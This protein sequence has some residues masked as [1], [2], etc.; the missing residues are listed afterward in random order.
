MHP[1]N[2]PIELA[3]GILTAA[4]HTTAAAAHADI[5]QYQSNIVAVVNVLARNLIRQTNDVALAK[6]PWIMDLD[7]LVKR[8]YPLSMLEWV[9][10]V[11]TK[12]DPPLH[13]HW[14]N[15]CVES[16][17][18]HGNVQAL[19]WFCGK[20]GKETVKWF[21]KNALV[22]A[23]ANGRINVLEW[24][25]LKDETEL[26][27]DAM[28]YCV[29]VV[30]AAAEIGNVCVLQ[31]WVDQ[32][33]E[34]DRDLALTA[35]RLAV[36]GKHW[37]L[38]KWIEQQKLT[39]FDD[40]CVLMA[41]DSGDLDLFKYVLDKCWAVTD[42]EVLERENEYV[43]PQLNAAIAGHFHILDWLQQHNLLAL[44]REC[45][46]P[47]IEMLAE[48]GSV[49]AMQ[50]WLDRYEIDDMDAVAEAFMAASGNLELMQL[51]LD[52]F[53]DAVLKRA[54]QEPRPEELCRTEAADKREQ[55]EG[56][57]LKVLEWWE[58]KLLVACGLP[59]WQWPS[60]VER[61]YIA[62]ACRKG[63][64]DM[65]EWMLNSDPHQFVS[66][67]TAEIAPN[68]FNAIGQGGNL[69]VLEWWINRRLPLKQVSIGQI[70]VGAEWPPFVIDQA[71]TMGHWRTLEWLAMNVDLS[72]FSLTASC[73]TTMD[74]SSSSSDEPS[75]RNDLVVWDKVRLIPELIRCD[76][77]RRDQILLETVE[78][79]AERG[80]FAFV[81]WW[82]RTKACQAEHFE[83]IVSQVTR[84]H[85]NWSE[86][87]L[88][89]LLA[90]QFPHRFPEMEQDD[91]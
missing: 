45:L 84:I 48:Q 28:D 11:A 53:P 43:P 81:D 86:G 12:S 37:E 40:Q 35:L 61:R 71:V 50:W 54:R 76:I 33:L 44:P 29:E 27:F 42:K 2:L 4:V 85:G 79:A 59:K 5:D 47:C 90:H 82:L 58:S 31:W 46:G 52:R 88:Y 16:A 1:P 73:F 80:R 87:V 89:D 39:N 68:V 78:M 67:G 10:G 55:E 25:D 49:N 83:S 70:I 56:T 57:N 21:S 7:M 15:K 6:M 51:L 63:N 3:D 41:A 14:S 62:E 13:V 22:A 60:I 64:V 34:L 75:L 77:W 30:E 17:S 74:W 32:G 20:F 26:V 72:K 69:S 36:K 24:W 91:D 9:D 65:L 38:I 23:S 66:V 18:E 19:D 8:E